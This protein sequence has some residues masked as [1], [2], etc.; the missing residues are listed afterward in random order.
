MRAPARLHAAL[1]R[2]HGSRAMSDGFEVMRNAASGLCSDLMAIERAE[3]LAA[4]IKVPSSNAAPCAVTQ[5]CRLK[6]H[7]AELGWR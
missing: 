2:M 5:P 1:G 4:T 3:S 6:V 7:L